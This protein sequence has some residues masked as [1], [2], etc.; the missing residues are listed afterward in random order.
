MLI[1]LAL[2]SQRILDNDKNLKAEFGQPEHLTRNALGRNAEGKLEM[3]FDTNQGPQRDGLTEIIDLVVFPKKS[4]N[5]SSMLVTMQKP[6]DMLNAV[7]NDEFNALGKAFDGYYKDSGDVKFAAM[8]DAELDD[9]T[10][11]LFFD[12]VKNGYKV[13]EVAAKLQG[14]VIDGD[15][16]LAYANGQ[17][18]LI[19]TDKLLE[20]L[21]D[22]TVSIDNN[23]IKVESIGN[24]AKMARACTIDIGGVQKKAWAY[25]QQSEDGKQTNIYFLDKDSLKTIATK[26]FDGNYAT[27][28]HDGKNL[29]FVS[30]TVDEA[31]NGAETFTVSRQS[32]A[33]FLQ[34]DDKKD[35]TAGIDSGYPTP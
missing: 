14:Y 20:N 25:T 6:T 17:A 16:A 18:I 15:K 1:T 11:V 19:D 32:M 27:P 34:K 10:T 35:T 12:K 3:T 29:V 4:E 22:D 31:K 13:T 30:H 7:T 33:G 26:A 24:D 8:A 5:D 2:I 21:R 23:A 9:Q 28:S